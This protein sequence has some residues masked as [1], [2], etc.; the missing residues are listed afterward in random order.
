MRMKGRTS[1]NSGESMGNNNSLP[2]VT[3]CCRIFQAEPDAQDTI[4]F[5]A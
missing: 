4:R 2:D 1:G 5:N 3:N